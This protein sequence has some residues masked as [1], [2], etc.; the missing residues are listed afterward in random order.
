MRTVAVKVVVV[1]ATLVAALGAPRV[2]LAASPAETCFD[3]AVR[4]QKLRDGGK[5]LE[6]RAHFISCAS[7]GCPA[8]V[9]KDCNHWLDDVEVSIP[10]LVL[11]ARDAS[12][13]DLSGVKVFLDG[14]L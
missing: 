1:I 6:A 14:T 4:G 13:G 7:L 9:S 11:G 12:D 3:D 2:S 8:E 10:T 5:L